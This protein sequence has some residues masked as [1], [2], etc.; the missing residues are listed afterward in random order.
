MAGK[1]TV[2][3]YEIT[4]SDHTN[5]ALRKLK[6]QTMLKKVADEIAL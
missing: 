4:R 2:A 5:F 3:K 1:V 6:M